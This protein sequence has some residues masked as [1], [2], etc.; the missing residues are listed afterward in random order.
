MSTP[1]DRTPQTITRITS[2]G[3]EVGVPYVKFSD[4]DAETPDSTYSTEHDQKGADHGDEDRT[5]N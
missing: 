5:E 1:G 3:V 2:F 4:R